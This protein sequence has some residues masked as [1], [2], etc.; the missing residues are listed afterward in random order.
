MSQT[1]KSLLIFCGCLVG[2]HLLHAAAELRPTI[3]KTSVDVHIGIYAPFSDQKAFIG[4]SI[5]GAMEMA[6]DQLK[7]TK[8]HYSFYTLDKIP[9]GKNSS[10]ILQKFIKIHRINVLVTE[11]SANGVLLAPLAQKNNIIHFSMAND[12][13]IAD[14]K[15]NFLVWSP[16]SEQSAVLIKQLK[17]EKEKRI[18]MITNNAF[19]LF[20]NLNQ[21]VIMAVKLDPKLSTH[22]LAEQIQT[23]AVG[24]FN[25]DKKGI[26]YSQSGVKKIKNRQISTV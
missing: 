12:P 3:D 20:R 16:A 22:K 10:T 8:I 11:G 15:N 14:G 7:P 25:L 9:E 26:F 18:E 21:S 2:S 17:K 1:I 4:R 6:R 19:D 23:L 13:A 24:P 5:F